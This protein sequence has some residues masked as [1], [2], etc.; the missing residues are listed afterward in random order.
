[1]A[2]SY[3]EHGKTGNAVFS[4]FVRNL[5]EERNFLVSCGLKTLLAYLK[6]FRFTQTDIEYLQRLHKFSDAFLDYLRQYQFKG[7]VYAIP[8]GRIV[9]QNEPLIQVEG[10]LPDVQILET[11]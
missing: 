7:S 11:L 8:E 1:M 5:P 10:S 6:K 9:F 4:L 2:Q 3:L